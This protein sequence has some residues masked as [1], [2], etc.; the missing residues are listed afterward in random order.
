M[1]KHIVMWKLKDTAEGGSKA[2]NAEKMKTI[3]E[4]LKKEIPQIRFIEVGID[5]SRTENSY[6]VMLYSE[7]ASQADC[8]IYMKHPAHVQAAQFI[9]KVV[10]GRVL[11][12]YDI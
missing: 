9:G 7:F 4:T 3:L 12:D 11:V 5:V 10:T 8:G 2:G 1:F 6:D